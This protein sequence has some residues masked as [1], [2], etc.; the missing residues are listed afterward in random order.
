MGKNIFHMKI[1][2]NISSKLVKDCLIDKEKIKS[3]DK[4]SILKDAIDSMEK[5]KIGISVI[6]D[7]NFKI[8]GVITD[9]DIRRLILKEQ[10]PMAALLSEDLINHMNKNFKVIN[11]EATLLEAVNIMNKNRIWDLPIV[12]QKNEF[13]GILHLHLIL[14]LIL[15]NID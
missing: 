11:N 6:L 2:N 9:G 14:E 4:K 1:S 15:K 3:L 10:K 13:Q 7:G 5:L 8:L 12:N